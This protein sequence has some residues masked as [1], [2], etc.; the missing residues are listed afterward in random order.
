MPAGEPPLENVIVPPTL[1]VSELP[2]PVPMVRFAPPLRGVTVMSE[3]PLL[4]VELPIVI[5]PCVPLRA[6]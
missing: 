1:C 3:E 5:D 2:V 4:K 6:L